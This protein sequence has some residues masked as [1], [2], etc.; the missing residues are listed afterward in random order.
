MN[1]KEYLKLDTV[2]G[3]LISLSGAEDV[4]YGEIID[5]VVDGKNKRKGKVVM[6]DEKAI[7]AQVFQG[8]QGISTENT[9][10]FCQFS[11]VDSTVFISN[12]FEMIDHRHIV[13]FRKN[14][15]ANSLCN[16]GISIS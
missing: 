16:V 11:C 2:V 5:I 3:S 6:V 1:T 7:I 14:I 12:F 10:F 4:A 8:T 15:F 13:V 9:F